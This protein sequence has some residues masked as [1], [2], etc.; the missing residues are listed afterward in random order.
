M[1]CRSNGLSELWAVGIMLRIRKLSRN[2]PKM[3][4]K[5]HQGKKWFWVEVVW[6]PGGLTWKLSW[7]FQIKLFPPKQIFLYV[8]LVFFGYMLM[9]LTFS[10]LEFG[11]FVITFILVKS[12]A[13]GVMGCRSNGLSELWAVGIMFKFE[14][15]G[16]IGIYLTNIWRE[17]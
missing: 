7:N 12:W 8:F 5:V 1:G 14:G 9:C 13:V 17:S 10:G 6:I 3:S 11:N 16:C 2:V 15:V 4:W